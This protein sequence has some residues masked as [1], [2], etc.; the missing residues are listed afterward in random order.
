MTG[1]T[2]PRGCEEAPVDSIPMGGGMHTAISSE[3]GG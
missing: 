2:R 3:V 1:K